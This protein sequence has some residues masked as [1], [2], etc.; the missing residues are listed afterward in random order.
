M[1]QYAGK[2]WRIMLQYRNGG[3]RKF[4]I[5]IEE[6]IS[7]TERRGLYRIGE[8]SELLRVTKEIRTPG[9]VITLEEIKDK[10][11]PRHKRVKSASGTEP[12]PPKELGGQLHF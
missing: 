7:R 4:E 10:P 2:S 1:I 3:H 6:M 12:A 5:S 11:E 8:A 9:E